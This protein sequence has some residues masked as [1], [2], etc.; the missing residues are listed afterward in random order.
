M[1]EELHMAKKKK[2]KK[3]NEERILDQNNIEYIETSYNWLE[4][5]VLSEANN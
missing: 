3:T 5:G 4:K 2:E 1:K